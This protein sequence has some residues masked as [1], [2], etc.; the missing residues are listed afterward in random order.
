DQVVIVT[1]GAHPNL[2]RVRVTPHDITSDLFDSL[3]RLKTDT[4]DMYLLH[5]D[6]PSVPVGPIMEVLNEH[7]AAGRIR[8]FGGPSWA[9][10]R[11]R[12]A[13]AYAEKHD[14]VPFVASSPQFSLAVQREAPWRGCITVAGPETAAAR[15]W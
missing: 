2:D 5:R 1:K 8:S 6:D 10:A 7:H 4:I 14:L 11:L 15:A 13:A 12:E 9:V 3:A